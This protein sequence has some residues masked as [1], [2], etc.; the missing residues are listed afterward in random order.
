MARQKG[1]LSFPVKETC[2]PP[3]QKRR[4]F[5]LAMYYPANLRAMERNRY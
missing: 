1:R 5:T 3:K 4:Y 2:L